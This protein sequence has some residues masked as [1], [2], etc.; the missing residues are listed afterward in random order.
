M[1]PRINLEE[2]FLE[3]FRLLPTEKQEELIEFLQ[4]L[5]YKPQPAKQLLNESSESS[6]PIAELPPLKLSILGNYCLID[7][8]LDQG[9]DPCLQGGAAENEGL[10]DDY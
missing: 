9:R 6:K 5:L 4:F 2:T 8:P 10:Y 7:P 3:N 1:R